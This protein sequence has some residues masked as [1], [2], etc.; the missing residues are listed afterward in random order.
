MF[1]YRAMSGFLLL[2][3]LTIHRGCQENQFTNSTSTNQNSFDFKLPVS[4]DL[5]QINLVSE[6]DDYIPAFLSRAWGIAF[7]E[8]GEACLSSNAKGLSTIYDGNGISLKSTVGIPFNGDPTGAAPSG[9]VYNNTS[10]FIIP[11]SGEKSEFIFATENGTIAAWSSGSVANT[12]A[13]HSASMA[14][15]KG[16]ALAKQ[17]GK[18]FLYATDF[19]NAKID[20]Y[21][22][23]FTYQHGYSFTD[24]AMPAGYA[25][26]NIREIN[27]QLYVTYAKQLAPE[28]KNDDP[29]PGN[30]YID[31]YNN[32]GSFVKRFASQG[33][34][35]SPWGIERVAGSQPG[36]LIGNYGNGKIN[37]FDMKGN[38]TMYLKSGGIPIEIKGLCA[39]IFPKKNLPPNDRKRLYFT[40]G[41]KG[42]SSTLFGYLSPNRL[43]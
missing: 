35:N 8:E 39:I 18:N 25:P 16:L 36:I 3:L 24:P 29:G 11:S 21:D 17:G 12:V 38:F 28:N 20:V 26:F 15:Y 34:L 32:D 6:V 43:R 30:G 23:L 7:N 4:N 19:R 42:E 1:I 5:M 14:V 33:T 2:F 9:V 40:A 13:D 10:A 31:I 41:S 27:G 37:V 22:Q